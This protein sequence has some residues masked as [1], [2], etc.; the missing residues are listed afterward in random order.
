[1][2]GQARRA[3]PLTETELISLRFRSVGVTYVFHALSEHLL[4]V[5]IR[6]PDVNCLGVS[7]TLG[8]QY[9]VN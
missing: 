8:I 5:M 4:K 3:G 6:I 9:W 7:K 2:T 1:M